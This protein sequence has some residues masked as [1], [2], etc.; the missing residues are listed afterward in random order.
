VLLTI[1]YI[2][3]DREAVPE[4][5]SEARRRIS[6][7]AA[8]NGANDRLVADIALAV[9][10]ALANVV[11]HAYPPARAGL[12]SVAADVE[13][14]DLEIVITDDGLGFR[15]GPSPG[16]GVGLSIVAETAHEFVVREREPHGIE[17]WMR[18]HLSRD[19]PEKN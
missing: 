10:E 16:L 8:E 18:F 13:D 9:T 5:V 11:M 6:A 14:A 7:F 1:P 19:G 15:P 12:V 17:L 4:T 3:L 2:A